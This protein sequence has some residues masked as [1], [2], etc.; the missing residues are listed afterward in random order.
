MMLFSGEFVM[1]KYLFEVDYSQAGSAGLIEA[2]GTN[3]K[4]T[5]GNAIKALG[6]TMEAFYFTFGIRDAVVIADLPDH[7][8]AVA[9][10]L[11][12]SATGSVSYKTT[13]LLTPEEVD[14][15]SKKSVS[16]SPPGS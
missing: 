14:E 12:V 16:Y 3:R 13:V 11:A 5:V 4:D 1:Q 10:S 6:G 9:L 15:A 7:A 2:G 8:A